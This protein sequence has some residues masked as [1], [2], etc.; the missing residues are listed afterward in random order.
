MQ[1]LKLINKAQPP[2]KIEIKHSIFYAFLIPAS[3][4]KQT[5]LNL[6]Q[7][8]TKAV[9]FVWASREINKYSQIVEN[10]SDDGEPKGSSGAPSLNAL[11]GAS[12][13]NSA[14]VIVRYFGGIK[15]GVGGLVRAY[16]SAVNL[17]IDEAKTAGA[18]AE[19]TQKSECIFYT[20]FSLL[21]RFEHYFLAKGE[22]L[23]ER[24]FIEQGAVWQASFSEGEFGE[25][26]TFAKGFSFS[27]LKWLGLP[28]YAKI[29]DF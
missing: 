27:G 4:L 1:N 18:I 9:H 26:F 21:A 10:Q 2:A 22:P 28:I 6:R 16:S 5:L 7:E 12:L 8:H 20:P 25:F 14:V 19:Y 24:E 23:P 15:L 17:A 3:E 11:R 13:I 29:Y